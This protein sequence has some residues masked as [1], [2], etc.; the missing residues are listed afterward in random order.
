MRLQIL[1][2]PDCPGADLLETRLAPLLAAHPG[3]E[4]TRQVL[5]DQAGAER[6]GMTGSP[7]LL[8]DG[9]D[10][11][12]R[13]AQPPSVSCR[14]YPDE[15]GRPGQAPSSDQLRQALGL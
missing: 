13:P 6:A 9:T 12:A 2:V 14:L 7:T 15:H 5:A 3:V 11:F 4:L 10:P 8:A 1:H